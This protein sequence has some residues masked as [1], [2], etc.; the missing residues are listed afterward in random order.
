[1]SRSV[2]DLRELICLSRFGFRSDE[3]PAEYEQQST[4]NE[5]VL[6]YFDPSILTN[7]LE[8]TGTHLE[9]LRLL[10]TNTLV[11]LFFFWLKQFDYEHKRDLFRM[12]IDLFTEHLVF[13]LT[14]NSLDSNEIIEFAQKVLH[15]LHAQLKT[16]SKENDFEFL[17]SIDVFNRFQRDNQYRNLLANLPENLTNNITNHLHLQWMLA[18]RAFGLVTICTAAVKYFDNIQKSLQ[19]ESPSTSSKQKIRFLFFENLE[20]FL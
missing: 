15:D 3:N 8:L 16:N 18:I 19:A 6:F 14:P 4:N 9:N 7:W 11:N 20:V 17:L 12:E 5:S 1:M 10:S 13:A 2:R